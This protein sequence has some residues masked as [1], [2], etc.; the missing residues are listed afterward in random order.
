MAYMPTSTGM[1][2]TSGG[3]TTQAEQ[4]DDLDPRIDALQQPRLGG[5]VV[6]EQ[7]LA[8]DAETRR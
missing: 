4:R 6:G 2:R 1:L 8:H 3:A 7:R 5:D